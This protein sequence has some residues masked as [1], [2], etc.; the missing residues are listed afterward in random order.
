MTD[1]VSGK[2]PT[3]VGAP[4][5]L[6]V[7]ALDRVVRPDLGPVRGRK[8]GVG[9]QI[10]FHRSETAGDAGRGRLELT[11]HGAELGDGGVVVGSVKLVR[12]NDA[13]N[14]RCDAVQPR[15]CCALRGLRRVAIWHPATTGGST[16]RDQRGH[17]RTR[18]SRRR[19]RA[20]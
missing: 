17:R 5:Q 18:A 10:G 2:I 12:I 8:S 11:D 16:S 1:A 4:I 3:D 6:S 14:W 15:A 9:Q 13:I 7:E 19:V 20:G